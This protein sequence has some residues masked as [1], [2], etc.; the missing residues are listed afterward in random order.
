MADVR[1]ICAVDLSFQDL[2]MEHMLV[3]IGWKISSGLPID[4]V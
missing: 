2:A 1:L 4:H 3:G